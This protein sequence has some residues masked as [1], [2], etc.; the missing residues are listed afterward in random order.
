VDVAADVAL[1]QGA[2]PSVIECRITAA[3][4]HVRS[5][6]GTS[7]ALPSKFI[8]I[9]EPIAPAP[10]TETFIESAS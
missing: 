5:H 10:T 3:R 4:S 6:T 1:G 8:A 2:L 7:N 9:A